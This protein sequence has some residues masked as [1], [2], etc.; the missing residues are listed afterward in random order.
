MRD[1]HKEDIAIFGQMVNVEKYLKKQVVAAIDKLYL[2]KL[3]YS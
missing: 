2:K 3:L 1:D